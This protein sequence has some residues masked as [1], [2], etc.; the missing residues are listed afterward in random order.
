MT[1]ERG[2]EV[3]EPLRPRSEDAV[4]T[5]RRALERA[6]KGEPLF[7]MEM[8]EVQAALVTLKERLSRLRARGGEFADIELSVYCRELLRGSGNV[9]TIS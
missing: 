5:V 2:L 1:I 9:S 3:S 6:A 7:R 4:V 8:I